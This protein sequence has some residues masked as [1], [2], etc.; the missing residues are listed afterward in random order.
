M[1]GIVLGVANRQSPDSYDY[2]LMV[3]ERKQIITNQ[4]MSVMKEN[5]KVRNTNDS[6]LHLKVKKGIS[7]KMTFEKHL[8]ATK[9]Q[10]ILVL[11]RIF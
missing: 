7:D 2:P 10:T 6:I 1:P 3:G 9:E 8:E 4:V 5:S 11:G